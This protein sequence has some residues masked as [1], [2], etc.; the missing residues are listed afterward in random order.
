MKLTTAHRITIGIAALGCAAYTTWAAYRFS[1]EGGIGYGLAGAAGAGIVVA[2]SLYLRRF[3]P[4][5]IN[6]PAAGAPTP[7]IEI[8]SPD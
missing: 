5:A 1:L 8:S 4:D 6:P 3:N 7:E 2:L